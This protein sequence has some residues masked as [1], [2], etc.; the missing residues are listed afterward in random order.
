M[1]N[2]WTGQLGGGAASWGGSAGAGQRN[3]GNWGGSGGGSS[4]WLWLRNLTA[5][6]DGSTLKT[7]CM[8]HGPLHRFHLQLHQGFALA[9]YSSVE[10]ATKAQTALNNC[11]LGN[12]T[13][14]AENP[15][16]W[17]A[18][19]LLQSIA[20]QQGGSSGGW[21]NSSSKPGGD[22]W[23]TGWSNNPSS[24]WTNSSLDS[25]DP[26]R[27]TPSSLNSFLPNDLLGGESM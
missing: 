7:L 10:E 6:I 13:I 8:Q 2:G 12:T 5:Q 17:D 27:A 22:T 25:A 4:P 11:V 15:T 9:R 24:L 23:S 1:A 26:A 21:R 14:L 20:N 19:S 3:S 18:N 16:D